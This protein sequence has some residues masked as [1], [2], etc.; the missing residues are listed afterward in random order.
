MFLSNVSLLSSLTPGPARPPPPPHTHTPKDM[1]HE[2]MITRS[3]ENKRSPLIGLIGS[4]IAGFII[5][6]TLLQ[7]G[8]ERVE[9]LYSPA[10]AL[11][12]AFGL[13]STY[14]TL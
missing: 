4:G 10:T 6:H 12:V 8:F 9:V 2:T 1:A 7:D 5:A 13:K 3:P 14:M 11:W